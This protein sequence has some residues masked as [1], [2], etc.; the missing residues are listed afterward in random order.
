MSKPARRII[1]SL[2]A[3]RIANEGED[4]PGVLREKVTS[5]GGTTE[6]ALLHFNNNGMRELVEGALKAA[7]DRS[8]ELGAELGKN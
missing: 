6:Q 4:A 1:E 3:A 7:H 8:V 5:P 2:S